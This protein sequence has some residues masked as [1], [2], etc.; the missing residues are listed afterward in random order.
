M[1]IKKLGLNE[2]NEDKGAEGRVYMGYCWGFPVAV[3]EMRLT[4]NDAKAIEHFKSQ[5]KLLR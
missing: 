3:K 5:V 4:S 2:N 1:F